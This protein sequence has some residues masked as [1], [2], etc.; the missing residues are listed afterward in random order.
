[1]RCENRFH[2]D[3]KFGDTQSS[4]SVFRLSVGLGP[5]VETLPASGK[6]G[7]KITILGNNLSATS[8]GSTPKSQSG[9]LNW[10]QNGTL[11]SLVISDGFNSGGTQ[12]CS[13]SY[14]DL[15]RLLSDHCGS[16]WSQDFTYDQYDNLSKSGSSSWLPGYN[17]ANNQYSLA[18]T[19]YDNN[20]NLLKDTHHSYAYYIDNKLGSIDSTTCTI[21][22]SSD[23]TCVLYDAF[24]RIVEQGVNGTYLLI[25]YTPAGRTAVLNTNLVTQ[26]A[27]FPLPGGATLYE[28]GSSGSTQYFWHRD[29]LG[30][31]RV[32]SS[33][34]SRTFYFDRA[35]A[36]YGESYANFGNTGNLSFTGDMQDLSTLSPP[37]LSDTP[38]REL[39]SSQ[40]RWM[41]PDPGRSGWNLYA[42]GTNPNSSIDPSGLWMCCGPGG[43]Q[44]PVRTDI[45]DSCA[46][47]PFTP[48]CESLVGADGNDA[49]GKSSYAGGAE[50]RYQAY[51]DDA[52]NGTNFTASRDFFSGWRFYVPG[53]TVSFLGVDYSGSNIIGYDWGSWTIHSTIIDSADEGHPGLALFSDNPQCPTCGQI[54]RNANQ[55]AKIAT[56]VQMSAVALVPALP[57]IVTGAGAALTVAQNSAVTMWAAGLSS[58]AV[59]RYLYGVASNPVPLSVTLGRALEWVGNELENNQ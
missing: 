26:N 20:G 52:F 32:A 53:A 51:V 5:F 31:V 10:N 11:G 35:F 28:A 18:G 23:G 19:S 22:G 7:R 48:D 54:W 59:L 1:L 15:A 3:H 42:Y 27:T 49:L 55:A 50:A 2:G 58:P 30:S 57:V 43:T 47:R 14:D 29:W 4:G 34:A 38:N 9:T 41:S 37:G 25:M 45:A 33:V 24:G 13:F 39:S 6:V 56:G 40:G 46:A 36:P 8:G 44:A 21:F 16:L 12:T 17:P